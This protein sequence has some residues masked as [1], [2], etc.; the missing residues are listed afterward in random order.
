M[1]SNFVISRRIST[2]AISLSVA[3]FL[4]ILLANSIEGQ[5]NTNSSLNS[6][7]LTNSTRSNITS[8]ITNPTGSNPP[9]MGQ[10]QSG[11]NP[12]GSNIPCVAGNSCM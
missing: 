3:I 7:N 2:L 10:G 8:G 1:R 12:T 11:P 4:Q 5:N 9:G 6:G